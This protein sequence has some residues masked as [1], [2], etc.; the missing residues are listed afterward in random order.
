MH[1]ET[2]EKLGSTLPIPIKGKT[3]DFS[4]RPWKMAEEKKVGDLR[5][6]NRQL[7]KFM[8]TMFDELLVT[9]GGQD[10]K[11]MKPNDRKLLLNQVPMGSMFYM[12]FY[13]R[14]EALGED[15]K[16]KEL[17]CPRCASTIPEFTGD[18][19]SLEVKV[20][21]LEDSTQF[22]YELKKPFQVGEVKIIGICL[23]YTPW[24]ALEKVGMNALN[25][26]NVKE[27]M[28]QHSYVGV[29]VEGNDKV[30]NLDKIAVIENLSK[31]DIEGIHDALDKHNGGPVMG[32]SLECK[33]CD[34]KWE[35]S[36]DWT[37]D[38]FFTSSSQ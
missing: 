18:L 1:I 12:Y 9:F 6:K 38:N 3:V 23:T 30:V 35:E 11:D 4:F 21:D 7:G 8:R 27:A 16:V 37:Y 10:W 24:D 36:L 26:G 29:L 13:L 34:H 15:L 20:T 25:S 2:L 28:I 5:K 33:A 31:R 17:E 22:T 32:L 19:N 14:Y